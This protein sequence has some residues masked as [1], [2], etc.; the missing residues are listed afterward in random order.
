MNSVNPYSPLAMLD[1]NNKRINPYD[2]SITSNLSNSLQISY[3]RLLFASEI[4]QTLI[5]ESCNS[6]MKVFL[7]FF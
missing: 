6:L 1:I 7:S 2:V 3:D 5:C 4:P